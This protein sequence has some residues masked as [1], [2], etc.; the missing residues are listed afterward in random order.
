LECDLRLRGGLCALQEKNNEERL[1]T[2]GLGAGAEAAYRHALDS[3]KLLVESNKKETGK[4]KKEK[5]NK[6]RAEGN[7]YQGDSRE[8]A[9]PKAAVFGYLFYDR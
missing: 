1:F 4:I 8:G 9:G 3:C 7:N 2:Q 6:G 5:G